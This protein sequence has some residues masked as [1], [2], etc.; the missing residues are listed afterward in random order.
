[1]TKKLRYIVAKPEQ[2]ENSLPFLS[3]SVTFCAG[4]EPPALCVHPY[5]IPETPFGF[6]LVLPVSVCV[7]L[8]KSELTAW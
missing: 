1:M 6:I 7:G 4:S 3:L 2:G 8:L 5:I